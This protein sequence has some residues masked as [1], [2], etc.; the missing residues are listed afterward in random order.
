MI[1]QVVQGI[2]VNDA[3]LAVDAIKEVGVGKDFLSHPTT[4]QSMRSQSQPKLIDRRTREDWEASGRS[5]IYQR[6]VEEARFI[7]E[8]HKPEPLPEN[9]VGQ[10]RSIVQETEAELGVDSKK[11]AGF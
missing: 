9:V 5:D 10:M 2:Q 3:T 11:V 8:N 6:A 4:Y 1:K 7:L